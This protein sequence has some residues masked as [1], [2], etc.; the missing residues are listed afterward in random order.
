M[1]V[2]ELIT[3][4]QKCN[5]EAKVYTE[6]YNNNKVSEVGEI[7]DYNGMKVVYLADT[8]CAVEEELNEQGIIIK[9][10]R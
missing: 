9:E 2:K 7:D 5:P 1:T 3:K 6:Q 10:V 8:L 4:L